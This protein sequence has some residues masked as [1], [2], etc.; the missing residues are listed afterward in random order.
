MLNI[1]RDAIVD[2]RRFLVWTFSLDERGSTFGS[3]G[4]IDKS[5]KSPVRHMNL[6]G[7]AWNCGNGTRKLNEVN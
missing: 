4:R 5:N 7:R 1:A 2:D 3:V 6:V